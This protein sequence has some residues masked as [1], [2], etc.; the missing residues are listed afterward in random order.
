MSN[1]ATGRGVWPELG[2]ALGLTGHHIR[3]LQIDVQ[4]DEA[5]TMTV[6]YVTKDQMKAIAG[7]LRRY[8]L[9]D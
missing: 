3:R 8:Q 7:V 5:V 9:A 4:P 6:E 2:E 1:F